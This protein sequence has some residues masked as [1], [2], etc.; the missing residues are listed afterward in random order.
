MAT[1]RI[2]FLTCRSSLISSRSAREVKTTSYID[3]TG[4]A[5]LVEDFAKG[6]PRLV[7]A[8]FSRSNNVLIFEPFSIF[9]KRKNHCGFLAGCVDNVLNVRHAHLL[10]CAILARVI[11]RTD[12][13]S[14]RACRRGKFAHPT[15]PERISSRA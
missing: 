3:L 2:L 5:Q 4:P 1:E 14:H 12:N 7:F 11:S 15:V 8:F 10:L 13:R 6:T 9:I